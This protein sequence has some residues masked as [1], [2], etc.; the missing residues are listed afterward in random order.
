MN[1]AKVLSAFVGV[2]IVIGSLGVIGAGAV[3]LS[4]DDADGYVTAGPVRITTDTAAL[5]GDDLEIF[6]DNP[7][8]TRFD[9]D[10]IAARIEVDSNN[11]KAVFVGIGPADDLTD[12]LAGV[13][14]AS[15]D[16]RGD[17]VTIEGRN[18]FERVAV[19][20]DQAFWVASATDETLS[21][22][23]AN[24]RWA[25]ALLNADGTPGLDVDVTAAARLPF[26][27]PIGIGLVVAGLLGL[28]VGVTLTYL[29]VRSTPQVES[30]PI[31]EEAPVG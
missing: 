23:V 8:V 3:A 5:V 12:Y 27:R 18:G 17:E 1:I 22:D 14:H 19:P 9:L 31:K 28:A 24:G 16:F 2:M 29:G 6:L 26:V 7:V 13:H 10:R 4:V 30:N 11:G 25:V 21:W 15:I 20:G